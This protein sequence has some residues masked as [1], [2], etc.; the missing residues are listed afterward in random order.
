MVE[1]RKFIK[2]DNHEA[3]RIGDLEKAQ[4][5]RQAVKPK[6]TEDFPG[7]G[8]VREGADELTLRREEEGML[9]TLVET[10]SVGDSRWRA[11]LVDEHWH[12]MCQA[13]CTGVDGQCTTSTSRCT[14]RSTSR[15][16]AA[17]RQQLRCRMRDAKAGGEAHHDRSCERHIEK[18]RSAA[19]VV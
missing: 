14:K 9:R 4:E 6:F 11:P 12:A 10:T 2:M 18:Q 16:R 7:S 13:I 15:S 5:S 1:L 8:A 3:I 19:S 17:T